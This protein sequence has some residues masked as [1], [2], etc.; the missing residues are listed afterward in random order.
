[1]STGE[2]RQVQVHIRWMIRRDMPDVLRIEHAC[3]DYPWCEDD[4]LRCLRQRNCIGMVAED[5]EKE[6]VVGYMVYGLHKSRLDLMN[7][8]VHPVYRR[9]GVGLHLIN[10]LKSKLSHERRQRLTAAIP[11]ANSG[12]ESLLGTCE[13]VLAVSGCDVG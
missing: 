5:T 9:L 7:I 2:K 13:E 3:Y 4:F 6:R 12:G 8:A 11:Q 10:K 1:M